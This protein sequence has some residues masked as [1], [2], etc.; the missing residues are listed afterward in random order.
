MQDEAAHHGENAAA[1]KQKCLKLHQLMEK[2][3]IRK[4][5]LIEMLIL[6]TRLVKWYLLTIFAKTAGK[7]AQQE[8]TFS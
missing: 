3:N 2:K 4:R 5:Y 6:Y 7:N 8:S 1:T